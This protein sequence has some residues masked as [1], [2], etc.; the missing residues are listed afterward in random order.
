MSASVDVLGVIS[1]RSQYSC[2]AFWRRWSARWSCRRAA[3]CRLSKR[4]AAFLHH[5]LQVDG[6]WLSS[7][8]LW[9]D[10]QQESHPSACGWCIK[11]RMR[12]RS[13][14]LSSR[15]RF[16]VTSFFISSDFISIM[17][18]NSSDAPLL[19]PYLQ[20][21]NTKIDQVTRDVQ[22][23]SR[24]EKTSGSQPIAV[25][26]SRTCTRL[27]LVRCS[28][29]GQLIEICLYYE[30][31]VNQDSR[32]SRVR[33][34]F[35]LYT[36]QTLYCAD[37]SDCSVLTVTSCCPYNKQYKLNVMYT[38]GFIWIEII[39]IL[40]FSQQ[41]VRTDRAVLG[42]DPYTRCLQNSTLPPGPHEYHTK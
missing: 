9:I 5:R 36:V 17:K 32:Y 12:Q 1:S 42:F 20:S 30:L 41:Q 22:S 6:S 8:H 39:I 40:R 27:I 2:W 16:S 38:R 7:S 14:T 33:C 10:Q 25:S 29:W 26:A 13:V 3:D 37:L 28:M 35:Y 18:L 11:S 24:T 21:I 34:T 4:E 23:T 19:G 15:S 31:L